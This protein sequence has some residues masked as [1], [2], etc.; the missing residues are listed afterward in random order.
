[1]LSQTK[2]SLI[3][4]RV[5]LASPRL[6]LPSTLVIFGATGDLTQRKLVPS[7]FDL[8]CAKRL[9]DGFTV[10][11][12]ARREK[13]HAQFRD[14]MR[15]AVD[16]FSRCKAT[17]N[18]RWDEFARG[19]FYLQSE[20]HDANGY[21]RLAQLLDEIDSTRGTLNNRLFYLAAAPEN[22]A[23]IV[24]QLGAANL[25]QTSLTAS[26]VGWRRV[27]IEKP[28]GQDLASA[29]ELNHQVLAVLR[30]SQIYRIDHYLGKETVQNLLAL[31]FGNT[32][33]EPLWNRNYIDHV[34]I[35]AAESV[36]IEGRGGYFETAGTLR[37]MVQSH[38]LQL[39]ALT[40]ME[41]PVS[42]DASAV[43]DEKVKV[44]RAIRPM[45]RDEIRTSAIRGQYGAGNQ[46]PGYRAE[47]RVAPDSGTETYVALRMNIDNWRWAGVPFFIRTGK[48]LS[49][50]V[51][52]IM[53]QFKPVPH[54]LFAQ[55]ASQNV[56]PNVLAVRIQPDEG[57]HL[58]FAAKQPG[59]TTQLRDVRMDFFYKETFGMAP[60]E[61][62]ETLLIDAMRGDSTLFNRRDEVETAW[63]L[64]TPILEYW[65]ETPPPVFPNYAAGS[66][67]PA[68]ADE[69]MAR[70]GRRWKEPEPDSP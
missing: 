51:T 56:E 66:W 27:I 15:A 17:D 5:G 62:Y 1:M 36:G 69:L 52:E 20:F 38:I 13:S 26:S 29:V 46:L 9:P 31:R 3:P 12:F 33:F 18:P 58:K 48:R 63:S 32:I 6:P 70:S 40:A 11:G 55:E 19:I 54:P 34:Q 28:F 65:N 24:A 30:E 59:Q 57:I 21:A 16:Q 4:M 42:F 7:L 2:P 35:S 60:G 68:A 45:P 61:A 39:V 49:R 14:E 50:R 25:A 37:D 22:Y 47:P 8:F 64:V 41:P 43:H 23:L 10:V 67:G 53:I 44:M